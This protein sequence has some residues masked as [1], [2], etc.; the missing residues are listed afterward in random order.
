ME[1][2]AYQSLLDWKH[3]SNRKPIL[4]DGARQTGKT[5]LIEHLFGAREFRQVHKLDFLENPDLNDIF[6]GTLQPDSVIRNIEL[7]LGSDIDLQQDL[8]FFDEVGECE[9]ALNSLKFFAERRPD[10]FVC[11]SGSNLGLMR[12]FPVGKVEFLELFPM[13]FEEF[14]MASGSQSL[15]DAFR[16]QDR[17]P[18][19]H[20][21]LWDILC[22]FYFVGGMPEAVAVWIEPN[23]GI[24]SRIQR[25]RD[26]Q[27]SILD[28]LIRDFGKYDAPLPA[29]HIEVVF[30]NVA[31]QLAQYVD[32]S[33]Q[34]FRFNQALPGK[35]RYANLSGPI[36]WLEKARLVWKCGLIN[37]RPNPPL[38]AIAKENLFKLYLFDIGILGNLLDLTYMDHR[39]QDLTYKGY[40]AENFFATEYR[41][42]V[43]YPIYS[44][45]QRNAEI[46]FLHRSHTGSIY[47]I[48]VKSGKRTRAKSLQSYIERFQ[49]ERAIKFANVPERTHVDRISTWPLYDVQ[50]LKDH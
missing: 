39:E 18:T 38:A 15:L 4:L 7:A 26:I 41:A 20:K 12:S 8:I 43:S 25:I 40:F 42:R 35:K 50:F 46:E 14:L 47:P 13:C 24:N 6:E 9:R 33:V 23:R 2:I 17:N 49:P 45:Q 5:Y 32:A 36:S 29:F 10:A 27:Q 30:R 11:A 16:N 1:R 28:G 21:L 31:G 48:E 44:W 3:L 34:R 22:D 19:I 37:S